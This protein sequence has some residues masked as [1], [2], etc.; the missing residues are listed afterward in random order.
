MWREEQDEVKAKPKLHGCYEWNFS[1]VRI[2]DLRG[3]RKRPKN[4]WGVGQMDTHTNRAVNYA[5]RAVHGAVGPRVHGRV[6]QRTV[7]K[8]HGKQ[9]NH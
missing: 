3:E 4:R 5:P 6:Q 8:F 2:T 7:L 9:K 1:A